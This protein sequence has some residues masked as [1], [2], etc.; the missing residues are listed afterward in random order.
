VE[1]DGVF[2]RHDVGDGA[3]ALAGGLGGFGLGHG[4][5]RVELAQD[6]QQAGRPTLEM[7]WSGAS[8][9]LRNWRRQLIEAARRVCALAKRAVQGHVTSLWLFLLKNEISWF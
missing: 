4:D 1:V 8:V 7:G 5:W 3:A 6:R 9:E 2:A